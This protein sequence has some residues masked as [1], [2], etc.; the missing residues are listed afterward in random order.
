[1]PLYSQL[2][3]YVYAQHVHLLDDRTGASKAIPLRCTIH[4]LRRP[5]L[6]ERAFGTRGLRKALHRNEIQQYV[7]LRVLFII[8]YN[9]TCFLYDVCILARRK[10]IIS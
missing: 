8:F 3:L 4:V 1:M 7:H 6:I 10:E 5:I 9:L 2:Y